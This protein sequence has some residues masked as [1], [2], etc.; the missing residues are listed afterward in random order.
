MITLS[1]PFC[2]A[3]QMI[4]KMFFDTIFKCIDDD[5]DDDDGL[6]PKLKHLSLIIYIKSRSPYM[7]ITISDGGDTEAMQEATV[8]FFPFLL[9]LDPTLHQTVGTLS[10]FGFWMFCVKQVWECFLHCA[11]VGDEG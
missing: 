3:F 7:G 4:A 8:A 11:H 1:I 10:H 5:V 6:G 2:T 9:F